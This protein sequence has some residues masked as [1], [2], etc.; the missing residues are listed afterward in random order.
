MGNIMVKLEEWIWDCY[1]IQ[2]GHGGLKPTIRMYTGDPS[3]TIRSV[4]LNMGVPQAILMG[5]TTMNALD[6][7]VPIFRH[8]QLAAVHARQLSCVEDIHRSLAQHQLGLL[9]IRTCPNQNCKLWKLCSFQ[10]IAQQGPTY[11]PPE[12][13]PSSLYTAFT[14]LT[15]VGLMLLW[16]IRVP[17]AWPLVWDWKILWRLRET[18]R[19]GFGPAVHAM[20]LRLRQYIF[21]ARWWI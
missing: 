18:A 15:E 14:G 8:T 19:W 4:W 7:G 17:P 5:K 2:I 16:L 9:E 1:P 13:L 12:V 20:G 10:V 11:Q 21:C 3:P 6:W